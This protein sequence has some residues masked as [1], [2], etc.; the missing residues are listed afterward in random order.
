MA[1]NATTRTDPDT[2]SPWPWV[3]IVTSPSGS[4]AV[5]ML[6]LPSSWISRSPVISTTDSA[7][8]RFP[9]LS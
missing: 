8:M 2:N 4:I 6:R 5:W 3:E 1:P 7:A 9:P